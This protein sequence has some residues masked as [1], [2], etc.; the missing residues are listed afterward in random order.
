MAIFMVWEYNELESQGKSFY[1]DS[2]E[3][4]VTRWGEMNEF[5]PV[6]GTLAHVRKIG[7][8]ALQHPVLSY[9]VD[10]RVVVTASP[11]DTGRLK[12]K[13]SKSA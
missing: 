4:A 11:T 5:L 8:S 9:W 13:E 10:S 12:Y 3:A 6:G 1:S 7:A 2:H